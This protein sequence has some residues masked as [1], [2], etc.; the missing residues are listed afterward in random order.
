MPTAKENPKRWYLTMVF[1]VVLSFIV[2]A[3]GPNLGYSPDAIRDIALW[4]GLLAPTAAIM[5]VR[6]EL[7]KKG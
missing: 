1:C 7:L 3:I 4:I 2:L 6:A 5:G